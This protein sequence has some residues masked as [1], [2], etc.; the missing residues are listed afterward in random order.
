M[1]PQSHTGGAD[2]LDVRVGFEAL[3]LVGYVPEAFGCRT[4]PEKTWLYAGVP[5]ERYVQR[6]QK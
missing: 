6:T 5:P 1:R 4:G 3:G 2:G